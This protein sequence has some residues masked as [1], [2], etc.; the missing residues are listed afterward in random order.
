MIVPR[1]ERVLLP[2]PIF[3]RRTHDAEWVPAKVV[4]LSES[5]VLF[6]P[7]ELEAGAAVEVILS[8]PIQVGTLATGKQVCVGE[9]VR[10][11]EVGGVAVRFEDCRFLLDDPQRSGPLSELDS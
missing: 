6:G 11:H 7:T 2:I 10:T 5:G 4:N 9:V 1:A 8:P 3:Y